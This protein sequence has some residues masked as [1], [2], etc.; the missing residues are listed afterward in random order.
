MADVHARLIAQG[1]SDRLGQPVVVENRTGA[2]GNLATDA[3]TRAEPDGY[4]LLLIT[5]P[6]IITPPLP[7]D[8]NPAH[9]LTPV[10]GIAQ[11]Y[12]ILVANPSLPVSN[13][14]EFLSYAKARPGQIAM[15]SAGIGTGPH[16]SGE[17]FKTMTGVDLL[18]VPYRGGGPARIDLLS[19]QVQVMFSALT[20]LNLI[21][22]GK[23]RA[24]AVTTKSR[25]KNLPELPTVAEFVP[26]YEA[27][28]L[29][30]VCVPNGTP[31]EIVERLNT[32]VNA[33][34]NDPTT[35]S[36]ITEMGSSVLRVSTADFKT[37]LAQDTEMW[38]RVIQT[39]GIKPN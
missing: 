11:V 22:T 33:V 37:L 31:A 14:Q 1:L 17:L 16:L 20:D 3:V 26:G 13:F 38:N 15:A 9:A 34:L 24:L 25:L 2:G 23:L 18:H 28:S 30:G 10:A 35:Q 32:G 19:G 8:F 12:H 7:N 39:A 21:S 36:H 4:T 27:I 29:V 5:T 6:N